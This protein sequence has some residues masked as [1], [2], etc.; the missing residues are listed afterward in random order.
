MH[1]FAGKSL[2]PTHSVG[3]YMQWKFHWHLQMAIGMRACVTRPSSQ[4]TVMQWH[5]ADLRRLGTQLDTAVCRGCF[6]V[7]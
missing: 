2:L 7:C 6:A 3:T 1:A 4:G 5:R